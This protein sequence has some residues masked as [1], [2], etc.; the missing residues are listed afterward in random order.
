MPEEAT[1]DNFDHSHS[2]ERASKDF[3]DGPEEERG[4]HVMQ[5]SSAAAE[6]VKLLRCWLRSYVDACTISLP[7]IGGGV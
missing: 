2:K 1:T 4:H 5:F 6:K 3:E 7:V